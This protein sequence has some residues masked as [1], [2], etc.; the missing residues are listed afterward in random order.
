MCAVFHMAKHLRMRVHVR[1]LK[2][3]EYDTK[4]IDK[5]IIPSHLKQLV[6]MLVEHKTTA[7]A[8]V[9]AGKGGGAV[10]LLAGPPGVGKT[11]T[12]EVFAESEQRALYSVQCSQLGTDPEELEDALLKVFARANRWNAVLLLDE[13]DVYVHERGDDLLQN[14][15][16]GVFLR[17]LEYQTTILF[18]TTNRPDDVDDAIASRCIARLNYD[19]PGPHDQREIWKVLAKTMGMT[20]APKVLDGLYENNPKLSGRDIKNLLKLSKL[21]HG[22]TVTVDSIEKV[23]VYQPTMRKGT[24]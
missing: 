14:S 1:N 11:L 4:L 19:V 6:H 12:A 17:V 13:A 22:A 15:I 20:V 10:V 3:Y 24:A 18:L 7:F 21:L 8:D 16:V 23:K 2:A 9:V 5:L